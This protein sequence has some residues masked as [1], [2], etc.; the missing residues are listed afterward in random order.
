MEIKM[1]K[2][3]ILVNNEIVVTL[4]TLIVNYKVLLLI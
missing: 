4:S 1:A 2:F 3:Q